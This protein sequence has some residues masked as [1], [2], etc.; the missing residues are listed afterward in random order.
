[1]LYETLRCVLNYSINASFVL[2]VND[3]GGVVVMIGVDPIDPWTQIG[4]QLE[5]PFSTTEVSLGYY[6]GTT[7]VSLGCPILVCSQLGTIK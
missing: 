1:M 5:N 6:M 7:M 2:S 4:Y 3:V